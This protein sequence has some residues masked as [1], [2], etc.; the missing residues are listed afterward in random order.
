MLFTSESNE[1][2]LPC[3]S[4]V[5]VFSRR[6]IVLPSSHPFQ[7]HLPVARLRPPAALPIGKKAKPNQ[8]WKWKAV[9]RF[10]ILLP[11]F[12]SEV[13]FVKKSFAGARWLMSRKLHSLY[14]FLRT[15]SAALSSPGASSRFDSR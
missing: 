4:N 8:H 9:S 13:D 15:R 1:V 2:W 6:M 11:C 7:N 3:G 12:L 14:S 10:V 5:L